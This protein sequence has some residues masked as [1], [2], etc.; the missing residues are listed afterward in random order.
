MP[1]MLDVKSVAEATAIPKAH[2]HTAVAKAHSRCPLNCNGCYVYNSPSGDT[3]W[4]DQP[5]AMSYE[6]VEAFGYRLGEELNCHPSTEGSSPSPPA[7]EPTLVPPARFEVIWHGGEPLLAGPSFYNNAVRMLRN[8]VSGSTVLEHKIQTAGTLLDDEF[9][10]VFRRNNIRVGVSLNGNREANDRTRVDHAGRSTYDKAVHGIRLMTE[11]T[12]YSK[13][14]DRILAV[15]DLRNDPVETYKSLA[16]FGPPTIDFLLPHGNWHTPPAGLED[17]ERR[18]KVP[19]GKW[20]TAVFDAWFPAHADYIRI[21]TFDSIIQGLYGGKSSVES[22]GAKKNGLG[23]NDGLIVVETDGSLDMVDTL[24]S[25]PGQV[26]RTGFNVRDHSISEAMAHM[27]TIAK[28][29]GAAT[30]ADACIA[31]PISK[32]CG[33]GYLPH[34]FDEEN[35][36]AHRSVFC[37]DL[38][39]IVAHIEGSL[40]KHAVYQSVVGSLS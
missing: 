38:A 20:Y 9:L 19:Y 7:E 11:S 28:S 34:R 5:G 32:V 6:T 22:I 4:R 25:V 1:E 29:L 21:R 17:Q 18:N 3:S 14:F 2:L 30:L 26:G 36:F 39:Y 24:K 31:C 40:R 23:Y 8:A 13:L 33:G 16:A 27:A 10:E 37:L 15:V 35:S 12:R